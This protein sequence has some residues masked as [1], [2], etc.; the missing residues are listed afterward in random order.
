MTDCL[1]CN[2]IAGEIPSH[3]IYEDEGVL[4]FLDIYPKTK[5]H[6]LVIPKEHFDNLYDI[7]DKALAHVSRIAKHI[8]IHMKTALGAT[9]VNILQSSGRVAQQEVMHFHMH[10]VPRYEDDQKICFTTSY[11]GKEFEAIATQIKEGLE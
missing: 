10:I 8:A 5:G 3:N 2:I 1:F 9:G 7:S 4:A 11:E 6:T